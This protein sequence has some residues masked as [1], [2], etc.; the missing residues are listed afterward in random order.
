MLV[1]IWCAPTWRFHTELC[2][3]LRNISPNIC[4]LGERTGLKL[5]EVSSLFI[6]N[7]ITISWLYPLIGFRFIYLL[8][9][10][11][12]DLYKPVTLKEFNCSCFRHIISILLTELRRSVWENLDLSRVYRPRCVRSVLMT[13]VKILPYR[14][15]ARLMTKSKQWTSACWSQGN[16]V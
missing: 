15:P 3:F 10:S 14:L 5:G 8:R 6:F 4:R 13:S 12:N 7:R 1:P 16:P 2:K 11:E 9:D